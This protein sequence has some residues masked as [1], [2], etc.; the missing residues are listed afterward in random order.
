MP[1][2]PAQ[3]WQS[4]LQGEFIDFSVLLHKSTFPDAMADPSPSVQWPNIILCNVDGGLESVPLC[5]S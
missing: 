4:I 5:N 3:L 1:P 2:V